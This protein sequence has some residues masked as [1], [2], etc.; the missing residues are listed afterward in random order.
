MPRFKRSEHLPVKKL[1]GVTLAI[2]AAVMSGVAVFVNGYGVRAWAQTADATTYTTFKNIV[3]ALALVAIALIAGS[4]SK[5]R[6]VLR[7]AS[8]RQWLGLAAVAVLGGAVAF[9]LFFEGLARASSTQAAFIHKTL[10]I[11]VGILAVGLLRER[12]RSIHI[13]AVVMLVAGQVLLVGGLTDVAF[14][15]GEVMIL[16]ATLLW[17]IEIVIAKRLLNELSS[18]TV[19][20]ARMGGGAIVLVLYGAGR[21]LTGNGFAAI[22][23]VTLGQIGWV[24]A[25]G[26]MLAGFV[27]VWYAALARATAI[28]ATAILA[29]GAV[30]T[31]L[32]QS[33]V[34]GARVVSPVGLAFVAIGAAVVALAGVG[35]RRGLAPDVSSDT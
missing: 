11:W 7:S 24:L 18:L 26:V 3:A 19:G 17:S 16:G 35:M 4:R 5:T 33:Y 6:S 13:F 27:A 9:A 23:A 31:A 15:V 22:G 2:G 14:G 1:S 21:A 20:V 30:I 10:V 8:T 34:R 25:T 32:L 28:D 12:L 29:G